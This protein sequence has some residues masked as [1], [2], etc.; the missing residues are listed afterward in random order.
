VAK[1]QERKEDRQLV[2]KQKWAAASRSEAGRNQMPP[3]HVLDH[4][5]GRPSQKKSQK[6]E[7]K[8]EARKTAYEQMP[9]YQKKAFEA[10]RA[11]RR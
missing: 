3:P 9:D 7:D 11:A 1:A 6:K 8:K 2:K 5:T 10:E 4:E